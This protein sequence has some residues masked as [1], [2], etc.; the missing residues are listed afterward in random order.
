MSSAGKTSTSLSQSDRDYQGT[1]QNRAAAANVNS[2][3]ILVDENARTLA[4]LS[5]LVAHRA[6]LDE[7]IAELVAVA[8]TRAGAQRGQ[9]RGYYW[10]EHTWADIGAALGTSGQAAQQRFGRA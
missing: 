6:E 8:R 7:V 2:P 9:S 3:C 10:R 4:E 5:R 1:L